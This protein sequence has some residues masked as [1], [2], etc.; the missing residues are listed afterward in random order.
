MLPK[1][2]ILLG[3]IFSFI[4]FL[5]LP[6]I[7][8]LGFFT[9]FLSSFLI[10]IDHYLYYFKRKRDLNLGRAFKW[11]LELEQVYN[12]IPREKLKDY[13]LPMCI[14]HSI[15]VFLILLV[16][17]F[18]NQ[19]FLYILIGFAFHRFLDD[20]WA[21]Y[22]GTEH[23]IYSFIYSYIKNKKKKPLEDAKFK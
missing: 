17:G 7:Q 19:L 23:H 2:H 8:L 12:S 22:R 10:D 9:I 4:L 3:F 16:L 18:Y 13:Y 6:T 11:F 14:F 20:S 15:E 5:F 1:W 21:L